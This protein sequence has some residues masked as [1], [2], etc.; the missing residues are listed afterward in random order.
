[1][2]VLT[3]SRMPGLVKIGKTDRLIGDRARELFTTSVPVPF[4][5]EFGLTTSHPK[6]VEDAAHSLLAAYRLS[7]REF[8]EVPVDQAV[9]AVRAAASEVAGQARWAGSGHEHMV[10]AG[11]RIALATEAGQLFLHV[12]YPDF[13][14]VLNNRPEI[15]DCWQAHSDGD[16]LELMGTDDGAHVLSLGDDDPD[17]SWTDPVPYID[18][19]ATF[20]NALINGKERAMPGDRI[21]WLGT[22]QPAAVFQF[23]DYCQVISRTRDLKSLPTSA[24]A[25]PLLLNHVTYDRPPTDLFLSGQAAIADMSYPDCWAP[26][27]P[28][29]TDIHGSAPQPPEYWMPPLAKRQRRLR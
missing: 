16:S 18:R 9:D 19:A 7:R 21:V 1:M 22:A 12:H 26:R 11:D 15:A 3:N 27:G 28:E 13:R 17:N 6:D 29:N 20:P 23:T 14:A 5:V 10:G 2:Y 25:F 8:F 4:D 24:G